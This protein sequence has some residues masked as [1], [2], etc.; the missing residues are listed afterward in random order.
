VVARGAGDADAQTGI[1]RGEGVVLLLG[2]RLEGHHEDAPPVVG[3]HLGR[4]HL[5][6]ERLARG[7]GA[8]DDEVS[9][10]E[11][12]VLDHGTRLGGQKLRAIALLPGR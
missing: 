4:R 10:L 2:E 5:P 12:P 9:A 7:R 1:G 11:Q 6:H 3:E 8:E